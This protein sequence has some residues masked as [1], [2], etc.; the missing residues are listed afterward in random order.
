MGGLMKYK[1]VDVKRFVTTKNVFELLDID[2]RN[3]IDSVQYEHPSVPMI[4]NRM[5]SM[6]GPFIVDTDGLP[7][8][9]KI[10]REACTE[11]ENVY[12]E[13]GL[14][15]AFH[16]FVMVVKSY[17]PRFLDYAMSVHISNSKIRQVDFLSE[18]VIDLLPK[19]GCKVEVRHMPI[20]PCMTEH[21]LSLLMVSRVFSRC[22]LLTLGIPNIG[23][24]S[25]SNFR[26]SVRH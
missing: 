26:N 21:E 25:V 7:L 1:G 9:A 11:F 17:L 3:A 13:C 5:F 18:D 15:I 2:T 19:M 20:R 12:E 10:A 8:V 6:A 24:Q 23:Y 16:E 4:I 14:R 22:D